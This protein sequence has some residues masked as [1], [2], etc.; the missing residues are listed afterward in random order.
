LA[1]AKSKTADQ[2]VLDEARARFKEAVDADNENRQ[3]ALDDLKF[4]WDFNGYQWTQDA[5]NIRAGRPCLTENRI[6]QFIRQIVNAQRQNRPA[7]SVAPANDKANPEVANVIEGMIRHVEQ[8]SKADLAYDNSFE[9]AVSSSVG[10]FRITTEYVD[11][12]GFDQDICIR[13]IDNAFSVYDDP[14]YGLPDGSDRKYCFVTEWVKRE[15]FKAQYGFEPTAFDKA[16]VGDDERLWFEEK[17]VQVVEYWRLREE[18]STI[19]S[20]LDPS[21]EREVCKKVV[22][23]FLMTGDKIIKKADWL[24]VYIPIIPVFGE[25]KNI[26][27]RKFRKSLIRDVKDAQRMNNYFVSAEVESVALQPKAPF[28]G[29]VGQFETDETKWANANTDSHAYLQYDMIEGAAPPMRQPPPQFPAALRETRM[30]FIESMKAIM[31]IYDASLGARSNETSGVAIDARAEQSDNA[32]FHYLDNMTRAIR[33][34][35]LVIIDL[36]PKVYDAARVARIIGADGEASMAP[37]NQWFINPMTQQEQILSLKDGRYD[38]V[39]KAGPSFQ[40]SRDEARQYLTEL[41]KAYPPF[42]QMAG[43]LLFKNM[44]FVGAE[45][46]AKRLAPKGEGLPP[47]VQEQ[48]N[49]MQQM[50]QEGQKYVADLEKKLTQEQIKSAGK[51]LDKKKVELDLQYEQAQKQ[52]AAGDTSSDDI[53]RL[54]EENAKQS[55]QLAIKDIEKK[56]LELQLKESNLANR[57]QA[58]VGT[59]AEAE[60]TA[61]PRREQEQAKAAQEEERVNRRDMTQEQLAQAMMGLVQHMSKPK[62]MKLIRGEDGRAAGAEEMH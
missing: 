20:P 5:K 32:T 9:A 28:I 40:S 31:G 33:Y 11:D 60:E 61:A 6:P 21:K 53:L 38:V 25:V 10:Y 8:W 22:E 1:E 15:E 30:G 16:G 62:R 26:E 51:D 34:A 49:Q 35:G 13:P 54:K 45:E 42:A 55:I 44:D 43:D 36:L 18:K 47:Q 7:I 48:M 3:H 41:I 19:K 59:E 4:A 17:R 56:M 37:I 39:V 29:A 58:L 57:E 24:G 14:H 27:G 52:L 46:I 23:Q 2:E 12:E 50:I